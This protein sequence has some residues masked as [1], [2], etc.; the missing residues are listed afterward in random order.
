MLHWQQGNIGQI[1]EK[2]GEMLRLLVPKVTLP[3]IKTIIF[4]I[5]FIA[6]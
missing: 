1:I 2:V 5:I 3:I 4:A 6:N